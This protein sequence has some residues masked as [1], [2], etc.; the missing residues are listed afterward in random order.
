MAAVNDGEGA[1]CPTSSVYRDGEAAPD[2]SENGSIWRLRAS[3]GR[4]HF[5]RA[6]DVSAGSAAPETCA[7]RG[8]TAPPAAPAQGAGEGRNLETVPHLSWRSPSQ[9]PRSDC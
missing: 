5:L 1:G 2:K 8:P 7:P 6:V 9:R 4:R 3:Q